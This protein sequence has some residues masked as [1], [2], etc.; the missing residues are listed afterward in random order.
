M[1]VLDVREEWSGGPGG[2][3]EEITCSRQPTLQ[4]EKLRPR[5][6]NEMSKVTY[7]ESCPQQLLAPPSPRGTL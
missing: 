2:K 1:G 5:A 6:G 7:I 4:V 3:V